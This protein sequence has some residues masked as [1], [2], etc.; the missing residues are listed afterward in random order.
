[1]GAPL[2][3]SIPYSV[4]ELNQMGFGTFGPPFIAQLST[5][6][7]V[8]SL[9]AVWFQ[10]WFVHRRLRPEVFAAR[11]H[12]HLN[13][14]YTYPLHA[15][16][17]TSNVLA[18]VYSA[19]GTYLLPQAFP[20]GSPLHPSYGA[21]HQ[22]VGAAAVT[23]LKA[24]F[25]ESHVIPNPV[26][27]N[28]GDGGQTVI[29]LSPAQNLTVGNELNKLALNVGIGRN[30]AGVHWRSDA[31]ESLKLGEQVAI[32]ILRD[33]LP[34]FNEPFEGFSFVGFDGTTVLVK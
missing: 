24:L 12:Q 21:G 16:V 34:T 27:P 11:V 22:T 19:Y 3:T 33:M 30:I 31:D 5:A 2:K 25:D 9:K 20:E 23:I 29:P 18:L 10:K 7:A 8:T 26:M 13:S 6:S 1:M 15:D 28:P 4:S 32:K 17:L 14:A